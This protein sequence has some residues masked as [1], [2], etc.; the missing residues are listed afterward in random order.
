MVTYKRTLDEQ[1]ER[2]RAWLR[3]T[4]NSNKEGACKINEHLCFGPR[5]PDNTRTQLVLCATERH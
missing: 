4:A 5:S 1:P 3:S 2:L